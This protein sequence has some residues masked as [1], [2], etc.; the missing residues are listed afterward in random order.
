LK[1]LLD[2]CVD[3]R[4]AHEFVWHEVK[5]V[6]ELGWS[7]V[8]NGALLKLAEAEFDVLITVDRNLPSQQNLSNFNISVIVL[9]AYSNRLVDLKPLVPK[10]L[11]I[12]PNLRTGQA[13]EV[14]L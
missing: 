6:S 10:V 14:R 4:L 5:T 7:G 8:Q 13:Q 11:A 12:L 3:R 2:E 1:L 9:R